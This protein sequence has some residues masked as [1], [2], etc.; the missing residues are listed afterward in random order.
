MEDHNIDD[1]IKN[2]IILGP[3]FDARQNQNLMQHKN[4]RTEK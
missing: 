4:W 2:Q 3:R 1:K